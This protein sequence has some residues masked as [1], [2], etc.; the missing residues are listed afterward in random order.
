MPHGLSCSVPCGIFLVQGSNPCLL[1][2][3]AEELILNQMSYPHRGVVSTVTLRLANSP[4]RWLQLLRL[5][6]SQSPTKMSLIASTLVPAWGRRQAGVCIAVS[7]GSHYSGV[8]D[9]PKGTH[10][11]S[12]LGKGPSGDD[13]RPQTRHHN[14]FIPHLCARIAGTTHSHL[15]TTHGKLKKYHSPTPAL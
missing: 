7:H 11:Q 5:A 2:W 4:V 12:D 9:G 10:L 15:S 6:G 1:H 13:L 3:P 14:P 8:S